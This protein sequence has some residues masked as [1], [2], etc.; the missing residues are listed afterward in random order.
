MSTLGCFTAEEMCFLAE[1]LHIN[2][3]PNFTLSQAQDVHLLSS[4]LAGFTAAFTQ[5]SPLW[6]ALYLK[7]CGKCSMVP[8]ERTGQLVNWRTY[9]DCQSLS[10]LIE[11]ERKTL[12]PKDIDFRA[13]ETL[14]GLCKAAHGDIGDWIR[15]LDLLLEL[16]AVRKQKLKTYLMTQK[17]EEF[18]KGL[19]FNNFTAAELNTIRMFLWQSTSILSDVSYGANA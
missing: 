2:I 11:S 14:E 9:L 13:T 1:D 5:T 19:Y 10:R 12:N 7:K 4:E 16:A 8:E 6:I 15:V 17:K 18:V 3:V